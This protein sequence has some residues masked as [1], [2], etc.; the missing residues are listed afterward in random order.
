ML[1]VGLI[2]SYP[3]WPKLKKLGRRK[4]GLAPARCPSAFDRLD[5][6]RVAEENN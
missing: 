4:V 3:V 1:T 5:G 6:L 2:F